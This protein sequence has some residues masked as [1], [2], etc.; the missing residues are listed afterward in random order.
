M[1]KLTPLPTLGKSVYG[2]PALDREITLVLPSQ[3]DVE[4]IASTI[5]TE[6]EMMRRHRMTFDADGTDENK[7][8]FNSQ[9]INFLSS[10]KDLQG[11]YGYTTKDSFKESWYMTNGGFLF[12]G[13]YLGTIFMLA[14]ALIIYYKQ[15]S[16]GYD[17]AGRFEILQK[18]GMSDTE[19]KHT[20]NRQILTVFF[21]PLIVAV[22]HISVAFFPISRV[23]VIFG[24]YNTALLITTTAATVIVYVLV[25]LLVFKRT[26]GTYFKIVRRS[27]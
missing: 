14:T 2:S 25:Y 17:D 27:A 11:G 26:A 8:A 23:M 7:T 12:L 5:T 21:V 1:L 24:V 6:I 19:V 13:I 15:I 4:S 3:A 18:V 9:Y 16:E 20:I 22:I 10:I